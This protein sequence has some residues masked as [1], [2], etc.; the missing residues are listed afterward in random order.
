MLVTAILGEQRAKP[1]PPHHYNRHLSA[2][3]LVSVL[4]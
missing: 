3:T 1:L 4:R 2:N